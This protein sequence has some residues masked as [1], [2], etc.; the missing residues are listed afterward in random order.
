MKCPAAGDL[1]CKHNTYSTY[2][3]LVL[4][5]TTDRIVHQK[6]KRDSSNHHHHITLLGDLGL[7]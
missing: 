6:E 2:S 4:T 5:T 1:I 3:K 7:H